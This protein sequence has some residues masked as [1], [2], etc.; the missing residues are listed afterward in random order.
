M[1]GLSFRLSERRVSASILPVMFRQAGR[2][3]I[4]SRRSPSGPQRGGFLR[5]AAAICAGEGPPPKPL[6]WEASAPADF[7]RLADEGRPLPPAPR[8]LLAELPGGSGLRPPQNEKPEPSLSEFCD[9]DSDAAD[10]RGVRFVE[11]AGSCAG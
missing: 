8:D 11:G 7:G 3:L 6:P 1:N 5:R 9:R 10:L 4:V 2:L